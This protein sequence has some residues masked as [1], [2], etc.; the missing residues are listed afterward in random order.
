MIKVLMFRPEEKFENINIEGVELI[1]LPIIKLVENDFYLD[2]FYFDTIIFTSSFAY[3]VFKKKIGEKINILKNKRIIAIGEKTAKFIDFPSIIPEKQSWEGIVGLISPK[4]KVVLVRSSQGN[5]KLPNELIKKGVMLKV[6]DVYHEEKFEKNFQECCKL[7]EKGD[8]YAIIFSSGM[9][10]KTFFELFSKYCGDG[11]LNTKKIISIGKETSDIL[12]KYID[13]F[14]ELEK[15]DIS[16]AIKLIK[17]GK[18]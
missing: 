15:P 11:K 5:N 14:I 13:N 10:A 9:I 4:E 2:D 12:K 16:L 7:I 18:I 6:L 1:N 17:N 8:I 3:T